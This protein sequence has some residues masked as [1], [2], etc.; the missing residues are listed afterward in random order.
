MT[1]VAA[2]GISAGISVVVVITL[3]LFLVSRELGGATNYPIPV[4]IAR[5]ATI[6]ILPLT[7]V[8]AALVISRIVDLL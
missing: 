6:G 1:I 4:E 7:A 3:S 8:F 2:L 5:Y